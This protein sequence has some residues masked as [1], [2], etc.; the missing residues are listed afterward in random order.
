MDYQ[1]TLD[2]L[3]AQLPMYHNIGAAAY[4]ADLNNTLAICELLDN[5][6]RN[7]KC[8]HVAG[9]NGKGSVSH[10]LASVLQENGYKTGLY[11]SPHL[12]DFR[13]RIRV[14]G[15]MIPEK[16]VIDFVEKY[17]TAFGK[18][19][20]SFFEWATGLAFDYFTSEKID[21]A[22]LETG[23]GG[24][25]DSTNVVT[26]EVSV[27]TNIGWD[28]SNLLGDTLDKIA[29][30]KAGIIKHIVPVVIGETQAYTE[31]IF[32][33]KAEEEKSEIVFA[34][35][36]YK[37]LKTVQTFNKKMSL[38][39]TIDADDGS[40]RPSFFKMPTIVK[41]GLT[42]LYQSKNII[43]ALAVIDM[44]IKRSYQFKAENVLR[45]FRNVIL[46]TGI[47]GRWQK[48]SEKPLTFCDTG[49]NEDGI[50]EILQQLESM[51]YS[52]L[53]IVMGMVNDKDIQKIMAML[54]K[55]ATYYFC[56]ANISRALSDT[57]LM[58]TA[59]SNG[60]M[61]KAYGSVQNAY[62]AAKANAGEDD[63]IFVGG[64]NFVVAEVL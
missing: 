24:R 62:E 53:H 9:T 58:N 15:K 28:H 54:P 8:I 57:E 1:Q 50:K 56:K 64:S 10:F 41:S 47:L 42:G 39:V 7:F 18:I 61:G 52:K 25:L 19:K 38:D 21:I 51:N 13:E 45:G 29:G 34:D 27:I 60:L 17:D 37:V 30:E 2:Y 32:L 44:L 46:N 23:L 59:V 11:T 35:Q 5:P 49:H 16:Y 3:F 43:T 36:K 63:L 6:Q 12:K 26:T 22:I 48:I 31:K 55:D 14:N 20:P 4:K 40:D 33:K